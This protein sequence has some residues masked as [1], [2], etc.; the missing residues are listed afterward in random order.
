MIFGINTSALTPVILTRRPVS[1]SVSPSISTN[2]FY[3]RF[4]YDDITNKYH[5][6][7]FYEK[8]MVSANPEEPI[9]K[10][11]RSDKTYSS[12]SYVVRKGIK[13]KLKSA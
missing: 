9:H 2:I 8:R 11:S 7:E 12:T 4:R 13:K 6:K 1:L 3:H 10:K 5:S